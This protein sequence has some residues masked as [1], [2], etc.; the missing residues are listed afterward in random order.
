MLSQMTH[1]GANITILL[2]LSAFCCSLL[3]N[4][5]VLA[6][7]ETIAVP[8]RQ[9]IERS[10]N[11]NV[12][13]EVTGRITVVGNEDSKDIN[14]TVLAPSG[15][16]A[17]PTMRIVISNFQF[18]ALEQG[19]HRFIFDNSQSTVDKTVSVNYEVRHY[20]FGFPQ[21][22]VLMLI[23]VFIGVLGLIIYAKMS[24]R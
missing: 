5:M 19:V 2:L 21:E 7:A 13:D 6:T 18:N 20:W 9:T 1:I 8:T 11:V 17:F 22:F 12:D 24:K 16:T 3:T 4:N 10:V 14:F 15:K 23:V